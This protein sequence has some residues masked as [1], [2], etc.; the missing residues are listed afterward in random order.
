MKKL[1]LLCLA[2]TLTVPAFS[3]SIFAQNS[4]T[5]N[6]PTVNTIIAKAS[7]KTP[8]IT[9]EQLADGQVTIYDY[10]RI[11]MHAYQTKDALGDECYVFETKQGLVL[12]EST[13]L[14]KDISAWQGYIKNLNK[15]VVGALMSYH[16][17]GF[18]DYKQAPVY[19]TEHAVTS[20]QKGG[21]IYAI[22][23]NLTKMFGDS[24]DPAMPGNAEKLSVGK[25]INLAGIKFNIID[26]GDDAYSVEIPE[27]HAIYRHMMG[28]DVH[29]ILVSKAHIATELQTMKNY[30]K[31]NY[32]VIL[33]GHYVPEGQAA[34]AK[35]IAYL[36]TLQKLA[37]TCTTANEFISAVE[38]AFPDYQGKNYLQM[39]AGFLYK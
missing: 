10:G 39:T 3:T 31:K 36:E 8:H 27:I 32:A 14:K 33:T 20:W 35:K 29:N 16:P 38:K 11:K 30:Q 37:D 34:V 23:G 18:A 12:L 28:S 19:A 26:A 1:V 9:Q 15:P 13:I 2:A 21:G 5:P 4:V 25:S 24:A 22:V 17:N 6:A 7:L